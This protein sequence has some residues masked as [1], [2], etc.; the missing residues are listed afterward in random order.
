LLVSSIE[1]WLV[2]GDRLQADDLGYLQAQL[3]ADEA[4]HF[5]RFVRAERQRQYLLG[6]MLLRFAVGRL[7]GVPPTAVSA[8]DRIGLSPSLLLPAGCKPPG[9][10][11]SHSGRWVGCATGPSAVLGLDIEIIDAGRDLA[12]LAETAFH[13]AES[14]WLRR[15]PDEDRV[16]AFYRLWTLKEALYKLMSNLGKAQETTRLVDDFGAPATQGN[17]WYSRAMTHADIAVAL[18][19]TQPL[20]EIMVVDALQLMR[21]A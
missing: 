20:P 9:F 11:L 8:I 13:P 4:R 1:L 2:D 12:S 16:A 17:G 21:A 3:S 10:S 15:R 7:L 5:A 6:R 18:C 19:S 14:A